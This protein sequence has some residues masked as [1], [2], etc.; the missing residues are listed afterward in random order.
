MEQQ[1]RVLKTHE[2]G[3][4]D[5][6][7]IRESACSGDCHK[8][9][10]CGAVQQTVSFTAVNAIGARK[11]DL[12]TVTTRTGP[13]LKAAAVLYMVPLMLFFL[14]YILGDLLWQQGTL[15]GSVS[16][17]IGILLAVIYDRRVAKR[18]KTVHTIVGYPDGDV[19]ENLEKGDNHLD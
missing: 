2:D 8:C 7:R 5:V 16:F 19:L 4:A 13:V 11:G 12:V 10:G 6:F 3:T 14:G 18:T 1:V 17:G 9:S 15:C